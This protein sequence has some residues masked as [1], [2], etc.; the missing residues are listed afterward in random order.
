MPRSLNIFSHKTMMIIQNNYP[1]L[2][3]LILTNHEIMKK[4]YNLSVMLLAFLVFTFQSNG[5]KLI[6]ITGSSSSENESTEISNRA[7]NQEL[8]GTDFF[9]NEKMKT[10]AQYRA[11]HENTMESMYRVSKEK[12]GLA[13]GILRVPIVV[14]VMHEGEPIGTGT[15]ISDEDVRIGIKTM[16]DF[17][18][19]TPGSPGDKMGV[20]M[21]IE[22]ALAVQDENG[23]CTDG[24]NRI[25]MSSVPAYVANGVNRTGTAGIPDY[26][27]TGG[28][29]SIK[30]YSIWDPTK[31]YNVWIINKLDGK[32]CSNG[33]TVAGYAYL[34]A[35]HGRLF[36]GTV[37]LA[38]VYPSTFSSTMAHELGHAFNLPHTFSGDDSDGDDIGDQ[39]GNDGIFDTPSHIRTSSIDPAVNCDSNET[40]AC[41]PTFDQE[42]NPDTGFRRNTGTYQDHM[43]NYMDYSGCRSEF[44]GGQRAVV[45]AALSGVRASFLSSP[46]LT[47]PTTASVSFTSAATIA[48]L[49]GTMTFKDESTCT[50][51]SYTN[52]GYDNISFLWTLDNGVDA[53]YTST[54]QHPTV[55]FN[56]IGTYDVTLAI[57]NSHGTTSLTKAKH[58][59][60]S[61]GV[62]PTCAF[63]SYNKNG[64]Y[65]VGVTKLLFNTINKSTGTF[66]PETAVQDFTCSD[67]TTIHLN[68]AY[69]L[70]ITYRSRPEGTQF[71]EVWID[72][73]DS[74]TFETANSNGDDERVLTHNIDVGTVGLVSGSV[75]PPDKAVLDKLLRM[76]VVSEYTKSPLVCGSGFVQ[77]ADDYGI[78]VS[79][80]LNVDD[81]TYSKFKMY[82]NPV[83][84][85]LRISTEN[86]EMIR[87]YD[88]YDVTGRK[89]IGILK[90]NK[91]TIQVSELPKG[92]Y[93]VKVKTD[94][95]EM[96]GKFIKE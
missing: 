77:R 90:A 87:G 10:D 30:E 68:S 95:A 50:P 5:Q 2:E 93:F 26:S 7:I 11:L 43:N 52:S 60:V 94:R 82:P 38:C 49:G 70:N 33:A 80:T 34:A 1:K 64:N 47:P 4:H 9:H 28:V 79:N 23:N 20:D 51:D 76:R 78:M 75:T 66:I 14:H 84:D 63:S 86:N 36:D 44:T 81:V 88:V 21:Q 55:I 48:C 42:T 71:L 62:I 65:G 56:N 85:Y 58:I 92:L 17:W 29:N 67:N 31:Y 35:A 72:W 83:K 96:T 27:A 91:N 15:N 13:G 69:D 74:G 24:I 8:C 32:N 18:R 37:V 89:V 57:T 6:P 12:R 46:G 3:C 19:K 53:P 41:D 16:N 73:D 59:T 22:F 61:S 25:D 40:N 45:N 39:C 54:D